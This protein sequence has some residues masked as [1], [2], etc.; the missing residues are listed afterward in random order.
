LGWLL[1][2]LRHQF[3][4]L[5][6]IFAASWFG[7]A[8]IPLAKALS[9]PV[10]VEMVALHTDDPLTLNRRHNRPEQQILPHRP[11]KYDLFLKADAFVSKSHALSQSYREA[12]LPESKLFQIHSGVDS[13]EFSPPTIEEKVA[14][15][16]KLGLNSEDVIILFVGR[17]DER[18]GP[19]RLLAAFREIVPRHPQAKL[20][21]VGP[22]IRRAPSLPEALYDRAAAWGLSKYVQIVGQVS[23]VHEY[24]R[25]AD[26][27]ALPTIQEGFSVAILEAMSSGLAIVTSDIPEIAL[28]QVQHAVEGL[29][30]PTSDTTRLAQAL[31]KLISDSALRARLGEAARRRVLKEFTLDIIGDQYVR[32]YERLLERES[33]RV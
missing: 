19:H 24:M 1:F 20:L 13:R 21:I 2:T 15:R 7:L 5:H 31:M 14:L 16:G 12:G 4:I 6:V 17:I 30:V 9:K 8:S 23:N 26:I 22:A 27:F 28:S 32:L 25:A 29:L 33:R 18:K 3:D 11:L 10:I